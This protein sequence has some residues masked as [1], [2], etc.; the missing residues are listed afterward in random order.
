MNMTTTTICLIEIGPSLHG[1]HQAEHRDPNHESE[2]AIAV[3]SETKKIAM[4]L[5]QSQREWHQ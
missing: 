5:D 3:G 4:T 1:R 2:T